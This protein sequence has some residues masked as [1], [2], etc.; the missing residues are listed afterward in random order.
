[1]NSVGKSPFK[2]LKNKADSK[3]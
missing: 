2:K 3:T 1:M